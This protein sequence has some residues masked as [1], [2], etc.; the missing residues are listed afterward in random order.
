MLFKLDKFFISIK[1]YKFKLDNFLNKSLVVSNK[2][3][4]KVLQLLSKGN[5]GKLLF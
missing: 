1:F 2:C 5:K 3:Y 4:G